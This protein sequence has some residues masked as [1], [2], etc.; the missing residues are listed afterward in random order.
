MNEKIN[1]QMQFG[2]KM[3]KESDMKFKIRVNNLAK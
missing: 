3:H 1:L 2:C